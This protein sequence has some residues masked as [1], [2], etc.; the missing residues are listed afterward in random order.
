MYFVRKLLQRRWLILGLFVGTLLVVLPPAEGLTVAGQR[1]LAI[2]AV[3]TIF[4]ITE[5]MPLP[6]VAL[7]IVSF[8]VVLG[9]GSFEAVERSFMSDSVFFI[10]GSLMMSVALVKQRLDRRIAYLILWLT[11]PR[12][13]RIVLGFAGVSALLASLIGE[14]TTAA[15]ML[16]VAL[17]ILG[18]VRREHAN[19]HHLAA[20]L[21]FSITYGVAI[22]GIGTPSGGARN[23]I[24]INYWHNLSQIDVGYLDWTV[25]AYPLVLLLVPALVAVLL[26]TFPPEIHNVQRALVR[27]RSEVRLKG[28]LSGTDLQ[29]IFLFVLIM[30][31]WITLSSTLGLGIIALA[32]A[33]LYLSLGLVH[34]ND[35]NDGV[36]W[37]VILLYAAAISLGVQLQDTGAAQWIASHALSLF[38]VV[39][40]DH[41]LPLL[42]A[43]S[44][45]MVAATHT[46]STGAAVA[47]L[48]PI[49][50]QIAALSG[51]NLLAAGFATAMASA[52]G[53]MVVA[54]TPA[55][56]IVYGSG[57]LS[58]QDFFKAGS[59]FAL[60]SLLILWGTLAFYR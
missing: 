56:M 10:M 12:V 35:I 15:I 31:G 54:S 19:V 32:G 26:W 47:V 59:R 7:L 45:L 53:F 5:P 4:F 6:A 8:Q 48:G 34:W 2:L 57:Y 29:V 16:P 18:H 52:F 20:L 36:N 41:G 33:A 49:A 14:H 28:T 50:L 1:A 42:I 25:H 58:T 22:G 21:L 40:M 11:G 51:E 23:A 37:G 3:S 55:A 24:M 17:A 9:L 46:M 60:V 43:L 39:H 30:L 38:A 13:P 44:V 27:L